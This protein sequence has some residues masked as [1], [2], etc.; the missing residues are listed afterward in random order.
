MAKPRSPRVCQDAKRARRANL[1]WVSDEEASRAEQ[2]SHHDRWCAGQ[3]PHRD[4]VGAGSSSVARL[5][6]WRSR[7][8]RQPRVIATIECL[9]PFALALAARHRTRAV[10]SCAM[11][12][13]AANR[14]QITGCLSTSWHRT[15]RMGQ[16]VGAPGHGDRQRV[17]PQRLAYPARP[18]PVEPQTG[19]SRSR[20]LAGPRPRP[21]S[22]HPARTA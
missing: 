7:T 13:A 12:H 1:A 21:G 5:A 9:A 2:V 8:R 6:Q 17:M 20:R 18:L 15:C 22:V 3:R 14:E 10:R 4:A 16:Q 11:V 19:R